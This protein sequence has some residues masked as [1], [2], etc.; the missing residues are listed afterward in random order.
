MPSGSEA[1]A[2]EERWDALYPP[3]E[4]GWYAVGAKARG[5]GSSILD[6]ASL[7]AAMDI[8]DDVNALRVRAKDGSRFGLLDVCH[9]PSPLHPH[10]CHVRS[11]LMAWKNETAA[12]ACLLDGGGRRFVHAITA[13]KEDISTEQGAQVS[14]DRLE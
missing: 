12:R 9:K 13:G 3:D 6:A 11:G 14:G 10:L 8:Y 2:A 4:V 5:S 1:A 7:R